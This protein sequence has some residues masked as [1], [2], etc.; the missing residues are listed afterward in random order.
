MLR[1]IDPQQEPVRSSPISFDLDPAHRLWEPLLALS[2]YRNPVVHLYARYVVE[3]GRHVAPLFE[4]YATRGMTADGEDW[5]EVPDIGDFEVDEGHL[6]EFVRFLAAVGPMIEHTQAPGANAKAGARLR[7]ATEHFVTAGESAHGEGEVLSEGNA[8]T[9]LHYVIALEALLCG[10]GEDTAGLTRKV[11]QSAAV[12]AGRDD[13]DRLA[14]QE[15]V[16]S[17]YKARSRFAHGDEAP[18]IATPALR[19]IVRRCLLAR[20]VTGEPP[21]DSR[22]LAVLADEALLSDTTRRTRI[23]EPLAAFRNAAAGIAERSVEAGLRRRDACLPHHGARREDRRFA[24]GPSGESRSAS[25]QLRF[26]VTGRP[27][28][29]AVGRGCRREPHS[30]SQ[31]RPVRQA[32]CAQGMSFLAERL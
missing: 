32:S 3:P 28:G 7:R 14:V 26:V 8:E 17:A 2:L 1:R 24:S 23:G 9:V 18:Q 27:V 4:H 29:A 10:P 22:S 25:E 6:E 19:D 16:R 20:L 21:A 30:Q 5:D 12:L 31:S 11:S 13:A 15:F